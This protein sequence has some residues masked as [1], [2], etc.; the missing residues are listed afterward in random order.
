[1][2]FKYDVL[3]KVMQEDKTIEI[4]KDSCIKKIAGLNGVEYD[5]RSSNRHDYFVFLPLNDDEA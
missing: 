4:N 2:I 5:V 3:S 1:M